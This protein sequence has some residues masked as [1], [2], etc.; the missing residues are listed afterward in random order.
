MMAMKFFETITD[1]KEL[2][3]EYIRLLKQWH[4]DNF[5]EDAAIAK[6]VQVTIRNWAQVYGE[7]SI[8]Y[9]GRLPV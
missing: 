8:M 9:E 2:K 5:S 6:A 1:V 4:P 3:R 7:L